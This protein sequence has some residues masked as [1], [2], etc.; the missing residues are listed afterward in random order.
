MLEIQETGL[1][2]LA[3]FYLKLT[4]FYHH[5]SYI[6]FFTIVNSEF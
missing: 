5:R 2:S 6:L 3:K 4:V 1:A